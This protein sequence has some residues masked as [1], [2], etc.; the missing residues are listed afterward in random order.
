MLIFFYFIYYYCILLDKQPYKLLEYNHVRP[1]GA[2]GFTRAK[3][4]NLL[5]GS[6]SERTFRV[7]EPI[8][9]AA[10]DNVAMTFVRADGK[11]NLI[12]TDDDDVERIVKRKA[13]KKTG[14]FLVEG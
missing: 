3:L 9:E 6:I 13:A 4:T 8:V 14:Q 11:D 10:I 12:F 2:A 5:T 1:G 7:N